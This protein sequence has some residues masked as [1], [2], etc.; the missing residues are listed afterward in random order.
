MKNNILPEM[1]H[2]Y[3]R[4]KN[5][6][7]SRNIQNDTFIYN[8][9]YLLSKFV[10]LFNFTTFCLLQKKI[11]SFLDVAERLVASVYLID[12]NSKRGFALVS[13]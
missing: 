2:L 4:T 5:I 12:P 7:N 6:P 8:K 1:L 3:L 9:V 13:E 10:F 11:F